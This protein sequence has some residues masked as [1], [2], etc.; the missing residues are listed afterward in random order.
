MSL[1]TIELKSPKTSSMSYAGIRFVKLFIKEVFHFFV[2]GRISL[3]N[4]NARRSWLGRSVM[5]HKQWSFTGGSNL[6]EACS[7]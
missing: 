5:F 3:P 4:R 6:S 1:P 2:F 7:L